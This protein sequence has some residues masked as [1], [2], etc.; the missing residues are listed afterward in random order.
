MKNFK[1]LLSKV[2]HYY[3]HNEWTTALKNNIIQ[4]LNVFDSH[5]NFY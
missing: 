5:L 1:V 3:N 4:N 2:I